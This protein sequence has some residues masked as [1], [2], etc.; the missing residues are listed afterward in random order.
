MSSL[1]STSAARRRRH[2]LARV[3]ERLRE[4]FE[5]MAE[6]PA[7]AH[8]IDVVDQLEAQAGPEAAPAER[9]ALSPA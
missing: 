9:A 6:G 7:P 5:A 2:G 8:L 3:G 4:M 1:S